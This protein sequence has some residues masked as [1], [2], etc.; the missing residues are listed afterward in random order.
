MLQQGDSEK[1]KR[2]DQE[3]GQTP[4]NNH[5]G[6]AVGLQPLFQFGVGAETVGLVREKE[7]ERQRWTTQ[8]DQ[9]DMESWD[10]IH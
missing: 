1:E 7:K 3:C 8:P 5:S 9:E 6:H 2:T 10:R 4:R